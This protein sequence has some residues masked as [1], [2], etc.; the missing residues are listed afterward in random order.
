MKKIFNPRAIV[1]CVLLCLAAA[2]LRAQKK[3][4]QKFN[5]AIKRSETAAELIT[6]LAPLTQ[7]EIPRALID[8]A[9]AVGVF[10]CN[11][12]AYSYRK[13]GL[14]GRDVTGGGF[15]FRGIFL[16]PDK[17]IHENLYGMEGP[18]VLAGNNIPSTSV[19]TGIMAFP[20]ALQKYYRR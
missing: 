19:P 15:F 13:D 5:D 6:R 12:I 2:S 9:E 1:I 17:N 18:D 16:G 4:P 8:K 14:T 11:I 3:P 7:N 10:P 20:Q